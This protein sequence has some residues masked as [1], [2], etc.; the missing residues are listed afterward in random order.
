MSTSPAPGRLRIDR[1][2]RTYATLLSTCVSAAVGTG[3]R[4]QSVDATLRDE[5]RILRVLG[6]GVGVGIGVG[7]GDPGDVHG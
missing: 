6:V 7:D 2:Q 1:L 3:D 5:H 4:L